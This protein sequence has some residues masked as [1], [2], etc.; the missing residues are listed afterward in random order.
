MEHVESRGKDLG[1]IIP[2]TLEME[3]QMVKDDAWEQKDDRFPV[4][5]SMLEELCSAADRVLVSYDRT[6]S[7]AIFISAW[8][9]SMR[10]GEFSKTQIH[11]RRSQKSH[12]LRA[13]VI[14]TEEDGLS[15]AFESDKSIVYSKSTRHR[16]VVWLKLPP[17]SKSV[18]DEYIDIR[19]KKAPNFFCLHNG[20]PLQ[21]ND[22]LNFLD[23][24]LMK[25]KFRFLH[26]T[27]HSFRQGH[28][29]Q[30]LLASK[31]IAT[32]LVLC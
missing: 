26:V 9:F 32:V 1:K 22:I 7:K 25:T 10:I 8:A 6:L 5:W 2:P 29:S 15:A 13:G 30:E 21:H 20:E 3:F 17:F 11:M 14:S 18:I 27:P 31:D 19:P 24:C 16:T 28:L 4:S 23:V 12:N